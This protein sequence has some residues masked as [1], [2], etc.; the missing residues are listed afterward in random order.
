MS[1]VK[2]PVARDISVVKCPDSTNISLVTSKP[3]TYAKH[4]P[5][6]GFSTLLE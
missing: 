6:H 4:D 2:C 1:P 3:A 5:S